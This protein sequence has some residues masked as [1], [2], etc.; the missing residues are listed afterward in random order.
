MKAPYETIIDYIKEALFKTWFPG[1]KI[2]SETEMMKQFGVS[3]LTVRKAVQKLIYE[4]ILVSVQGLGTY[5]TE[6]AGSPHRNV[7]KVLTL[8]PSHNT[9][10]NWMISTG[11]FSTIEKFNMS[12]VMAN[13]FVGDA[14]RLRKQIK[15]VLNQEFAGVIMM[16]N[17]KLL[18]VPE[19]Q[20]LLEKNIPKIFVDR[21]IEGYHIP[22]VV[23]DAVKASFQLGSHLR[24]THHVKRAIFVTEED[25][26]IGSVKDR[27]TG[28]QKGMEASVDLLV[29]GDYS[30]IDN[31]ALDIRDGKYDCVAFCHDNLAIRGIT[32]F[33]RFGIRVPEDVKI[34]GFDDKAASRY[35]TPTITTA[36]Q[37][38]IE[39]GELA[40]LMMSR[41]IKG[42]KVPDIST[43]PMKP[44]IRESCGCEHRFE[45]QV[46]EETVPDFQE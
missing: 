20:A 8:L 40:A 1:D 12:T 31:L 41:I 44:I 17:P 29:E 25:L 14:A 33:P 36:R 28:F 6:F 15:T 21:T 35:T 4:D 10:R 42:E 32:G 5:V 23:S 2:P 24:K 7:K 38:F 46:F 39:I 26:C 34:V 11:I 30:K 37:N 9:S 16:P 19:I 45:N 3:R 13:I 43:V 22:A 18:A 27:Y